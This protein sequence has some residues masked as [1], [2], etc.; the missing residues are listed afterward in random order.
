MESAHRMMWTIWFSLLI[1]MAGYTALCFFAAARGTPDPIMIRALSLVASA[2]VVVLFVL[3]RKLIPAGT[4]VTA[5]GE[6]SVARA[7][8]KSGNILT[9]AL[10]LSIALYGLVLH[11]LGFANRQVSP[12]FIAGFILMILYFPRKHVETR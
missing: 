12:I 2:E 9:W 1:A 11:Y 5:Q 4:P 8:W 6:N 3:R 7:R 10:S